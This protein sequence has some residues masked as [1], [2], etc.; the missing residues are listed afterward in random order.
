M[1]EIL[2]WGTITVF[3]LVSAIF[4]FLKKEMV[5]GFLSKLM[6]IKAIGFILILNSIWG[7]SQ[8]KTFP[9]I[10][11]VLLFAS[12]VWR[13]IFTKNSIRFQ[14]KYYQRWVHGVLLSIGALISGFLF[15]SA[16]NPNLTMKFLF[17]SSYKELK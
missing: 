12:G 1:S 8:Q 9:K 4:H 14:Q 3:F 10:A 13:L 11:G 17:F 7:L 2:F 15:I 5:D 16:F 6:I